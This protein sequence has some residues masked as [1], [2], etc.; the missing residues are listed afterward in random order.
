MVRQKEWGKLKD[1]EIYIIRI[2]VFINLFMYFIIKF[3]RKIQFSLENG[4]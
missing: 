2:F 1:G 4:K 3:I